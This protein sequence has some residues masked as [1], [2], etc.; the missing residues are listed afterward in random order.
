MS[1]DWN[2]EEFDYYGNRYTHYGNEVEVEETYYKTKSKKELEEF[3]K[4]QKANN[5]SGDCFEKN[6]ELFMKL[7]KTNP[8]IKYCIVKQTFI[9]SGNSIEHAF[10]IDGDFIIDHAQKKRMKLRRIEYE[11]YYRINGYRIWD[12]HNIKPLNYYLY[13]Y[14][15]SNVK[16]L[17]GGNIPIQKGKWEIAKD[18]VI[19]L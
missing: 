11:R 4:Y 2:L 8:H 1:H 3:D 5:G 10:C 17:Y 9:N 7:S 18:N 19:N 6:Y 12:I 14:K 16:D 15:M 13:Y